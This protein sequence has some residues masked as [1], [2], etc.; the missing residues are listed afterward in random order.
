MMQKKENKEMKNEIKI[1][2]YLWKSDK[3]ELWVFLLSFVGS[4]IW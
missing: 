1:I 2:K 3:K 4:D